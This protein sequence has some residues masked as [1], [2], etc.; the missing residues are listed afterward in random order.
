MNK[1]KTIRK[2]LCILLI[3]VI[4]ACAQKEKEVI[5]VYSRYENI[6]EY[7]NYLEKV[8]DDNLLTYIFTEGDNG[9]YYLY[10]ENNNKYFS[11]TYLNVYLD[12][13]GKNEAY[14]SD[15]NYLIRPNDYLNVIELYLD[16]EPSY[17]ALD[18]SENFKLKYEEK[19]NYDFFY[20]DYL[21]KGAICILYDGKLNDDVALRILKKEY[22]IGVLTDYF[23]NNIFIFEKTDDNEFPEIVDSL[24][25]GYL[26][27]ENKEIQ[28]Y[29]NNELIIEDIMK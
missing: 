11:R 21:D 16:S 18:Q 15:R 4:T 20:E 27:F 10:L 19:L 29:K 2:A 14:I 24:Y 25:Q 3:F 12:E 13:D 28:L 7:S 22:V 9:L 8:N 6:E 17:Y 23:F 1:M 26:D 5:D